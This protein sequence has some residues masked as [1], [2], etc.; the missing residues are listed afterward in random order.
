MN[1]YLLPSSTC[2]T[3]T[4]IYPFCG[5]ATSFHLHSHSGD[6]L[7]VQPF[8]QALYNSYQY[9]GH[10]GEIYEVLLEFAISIGVEIRFGQQVEEY[11]EVE[12]GKTGRGRAGVVVNGDMIEADVVVG[13]DGVKSAARKL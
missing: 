1:I 6:L 11:Y 4:R 9:N 7:T 10:R 8:P 5:H 12:G 2:D 13:A 3:S